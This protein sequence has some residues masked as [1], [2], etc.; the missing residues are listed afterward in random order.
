MSTVSDPD[1]PSG[2]PPTAVERLEAWY[3]E[4]PARFW[5][6]AT[7]GPLAA[8]VVGVLVAPEL[9][10]DRF[11]WQYLWG[12]VVADSQGRCVA[13][14]G[15][16]AC[17]GYSAVSY[18][19]YGPILLLALFGIV[20]FLT[21]FEI[22]IDARFFLAMA[23]IVVFGSLVRVMEDTILFEAPI[24]YA[25]ISPM[26]YFTLAA[27]TIG[28]LAL[29]LLAERVRRER[30]VPAALAVLAVPAVL[31]V[32]LHVA[33]DAGLGGGSF[34]T[35]PP[36]YL[37]AFVVSVGFAVVAADTWHRDRVDPLVVAFAAGI[38]GLLTVVYLS[39]QWVL[40]DP[41]S[42]AWVGRTYVTDVLPTA[43]AGTVFITFAVTV[44]FWLLER[45]GVDRASIFVAAIPVAMLFG[46]VLDAWATTIAISNPFDFPLGAYSEK[47]PAS[48]FLLL[49]LGWPVW[50][51]VKIGLV[52]SIVWLFE[53]EYEEDFEDRPVLAGLMKFAV[54]VLGLG[55]GIRSLGRVTLGV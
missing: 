39:A 27:L 52:L 41:W 21:R 43:L 13:Q 31:L 2:R 11:I 8:V 46:H 24:Q 38:V 15:V 14:G 55:P 23:P 28:S 53:V 51:A 26:I 34:A 33:V 32:L 4:N 30:D 20:E 9:V 7:L 22:E 12:P 5:L 3:D 36:T 49:E 47:H 18:I 10:W 48:N 16:T 35:V 37:T 25:M 44:P 17:P 50:L 40:G 54:M 19:V 1:R 6:A 29:G 42:T 45:R